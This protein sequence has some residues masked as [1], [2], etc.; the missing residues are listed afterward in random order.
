MKLPT[1]M[2]FHEDIRLFI[3]KPRGLLDETSV[4]KAVTVLRALEKN[5]T[6]A[7]NGFSDTSAIDR[8]ELNYQYVI[9]VSL[10]GLNVRRSSTGEIGDSGDRLRGRPLFPVACHNY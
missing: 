6:E 3:Y 8:V 1:D 5:Q 9:Q 7:L 10:S 4:D 2:E